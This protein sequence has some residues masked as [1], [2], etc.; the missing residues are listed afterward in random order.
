MLND[1]GVPANCGWARYPYFDYNPFLAPRRRITECDRYII[2]STTHIVSFELCDTG[3]LGYMG[4]QVFSLKDASYN[5]QVYTVPFSMGCFEMP[6]NS[7]FGSVKVVYKNSHLH[8]VPMEGGARII[9]ADFPRFGYHR[10]LRGELVLFEPAG[11][12][13]L[14]THSPW[15][16]NKNAFRCLRCSPWYYAEGVIQFGSTEIVFTK[17]KAWGIFIWERGVRPRADTHFWAG[18]CGINDN[19]QISFSVGY[20]SADSSNGTENVF[21]FEGRLYKL[22][23]V[24]FL[25]SP[26]DWLKPWHFTSSDNRLEMEFKPYNEIS[27]YNQIFFHI[28]KRRRVFGSFSGKIIL[29]DGSERDF[30]NITGIA[31]RRKMQF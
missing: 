3:Y 13:S 22:D 18:G 19:R 24:T 2:L 9:K 20:G 21:F 29:D 6:Y 12:E 14:V 26:N 4:V 5:T 1:E 27:E 25:I 31:E 30:R 15:L 17:T 11:V 7:L 8:F 23:Q 16:R 28:E 10:S